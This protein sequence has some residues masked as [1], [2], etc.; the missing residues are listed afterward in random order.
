MYVPFSEEWVNCLHSNIDGCDNQSLLSK[1]VTI[2]CYKGKS[3][4]SEILKIPFVKLLENNGW[5][6]I[7]TENSD[8]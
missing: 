8:Y 4:W 6:M 5:I 3:T 7:M 1:K 2:C